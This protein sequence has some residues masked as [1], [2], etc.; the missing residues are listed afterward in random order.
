MA[1]SSTPNLPFPCGRGS[2]T[3]C[4]T[5]RHSTPHVYL[6]NSIITRRTIK[7]EV[8]MRQATDKQTTLKRNV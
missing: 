2:G 8:R 1:K 5:I 3:L 4:N 7:H 6:L